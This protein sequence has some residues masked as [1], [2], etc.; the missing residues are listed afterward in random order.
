MQMNEKIKGEKWK[1]K[2]YRIKEKKIQDARCTINNQDT[3][4]DVGARNYAKLPS[5]YTAIISKYN[6]HVSFITH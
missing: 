2:K 1:Q 4:D 5:I 6:T 3:V